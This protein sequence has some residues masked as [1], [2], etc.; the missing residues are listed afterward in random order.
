MLNIVPL[1]NLALLYLQ[2]KGDR[3]VVSGYR[4]ELNDVDL[5]QLHTTL[6]PGTPFPP[7]LSSQG[8]PC[9]LSELQLQRGGSYRVVKDSE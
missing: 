5:I 1:E 4:R 6:S 3:S 2:I 7:F 8:P 9:L